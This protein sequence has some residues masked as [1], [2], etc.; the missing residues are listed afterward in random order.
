MVTHRIVTAFQRP[1]MS[2]NEQRRAHYH[3]QAKAKKLV[4][5]VAAWQAKSQKIKGLGPS[6]VTI[7]WYAPDRRKRDTDGLGFFLKSVLD[8]LKQAGVWPD[9]HSDWVTETR[10]SIDKTQTDNPR[11]EIIIEETQPC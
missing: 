10:L 7:I 11:I 5:D 3:Q 8:G 6:I 4:G 2:A 1:P 9:D